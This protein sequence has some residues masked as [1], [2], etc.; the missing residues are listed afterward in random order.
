MYR[1]DNHSDGG[2]CYLTF[3][4]CSVNLGKGRR[5]YQRT[6]KKEWNVVFA[7]NRFYPLGGGFIPKSGVFQCLEPGLYLFTLTV[8]TYDG[9]K[10]LLIIRK[11][12][13]VTKSLCIIF[14][15]RHQQGQPLSFFCKSLFLSLQKC[16]AQI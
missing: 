5:R 1:D 15:T 10:C 7:T 8:C 3:T 6:V 13:K 9:K 2:E 16:M 14:F 4:G 11:N 12:E